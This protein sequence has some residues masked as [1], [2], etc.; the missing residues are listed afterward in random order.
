[1]EFR[2][3]KSIFAIED[4][5]GPFEGWTADEYWNGW[6]CPYFERAATL[7][8]VD[9]WNQVTFENDVFMARYDEERDQFCFHAESDGE[10]E[11]FGAQSINVDGRPITVYGIG[12]HCWIWEEAA[13]GPPMYPA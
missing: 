9:A 3:R 10:W 12:A 2:F 11:C 1:M 4:W 13:S 5:L 6:A 8:I 7:R